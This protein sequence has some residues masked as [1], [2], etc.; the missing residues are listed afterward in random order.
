LTK[1][2]IDLVAI[3]ARAQL[4]KRVR[5]TFAE[6]GGRSVRIC[7]ALRHFLVQ[8]EIMDGDV[9]VLLERVHALEAEC[10]KDAELLDNINE[11]LE[12]QD[13]ESIALSLHNLA[14]GESVD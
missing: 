10:Q 2:P 5:A 1:S 14:K 6:M 11:Y 8:L 12:V 7:S 13:L 4:G 9:T 3:E